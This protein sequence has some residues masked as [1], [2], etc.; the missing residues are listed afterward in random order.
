MPNFPWA[1]KAKFL[2]AVLALSM[3]LFRLLLVYVEPD[4]I[5]Y[6]GL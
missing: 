2:I 5:R 1:G 4:R 3:I 6:Q